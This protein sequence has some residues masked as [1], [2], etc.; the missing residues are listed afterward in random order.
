MTNETTVQDK[1][2]IM[3]E[4]LNELLRG[5]RKMKTRAEKNAQRAK[6]AARKTARAN[7]KRNARGA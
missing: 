3:R 4:A 5:A 6:K 7:R 1:K 2:K